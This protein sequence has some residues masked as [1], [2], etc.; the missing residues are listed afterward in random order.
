MDNP[1]EETI[2]R[3]PKMLEQPKDVVYEPKDVNKF[4]SIICTVDAYPEAEFLWTRERAGDKVEID[5][6]TEPRYTMINGVLIIHEPAA[7]EEDDGKYQCTATNKFGSIFSNTIALDFGCKRLSSLIVTSVP[8]LILLI[9]FTR[10]SQI[11]KGSSVSHSIP[12]GF[13]GV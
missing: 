5:P 7:D 13:R 8:S 2:E 6:N 3:G 10:L 1:D 12:M 4:T 9:R 11:P